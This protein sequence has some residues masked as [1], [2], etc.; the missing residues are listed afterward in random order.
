MTG[1]PASRLLACSAGAVLLLYGAG[2]A[3]NP[4]VDGQWSI[5]HDWSD[6]IDDPA[7]NND[8]DQEIAHGALLS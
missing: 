6:Q 5:K 8:P 1:F 2:A 3:Q 7:T 4:A